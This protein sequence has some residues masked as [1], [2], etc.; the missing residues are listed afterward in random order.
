MSFTALWYFIGP[1]FVQ[2]LPD[3]SLVKY[4]H[5]C[6]LQH[7]GTDL[8]W[9]IYVGFPV[10]PSKDEITCV[11]HGI[12]VPSFL[13]GHNEITCVMHRGF[14]T[15]TLLHA[16][17]FTHTHTLSHTEAFTH[18]PF[19]TQRLLHTDTF[20]HRHF[21]PQKLLH[22]HTHSLAFLLHTHTHTFTHKG[23]YTQTLTQKLEQCLPMQVEF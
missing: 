2:T 15:Q 8:F 13:L 17:A 7:H 19:Y 14:Y 1:F 18:R 6:D 23:F 11:I 9:P 12:M 20:T 4:S 22:T 5:M 16:D 21:Y 10:F 3:I